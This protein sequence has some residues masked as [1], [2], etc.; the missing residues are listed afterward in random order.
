MPVQQKYNLVFK[1]QKAMLQKTVTAFQYSVMY[2][3]EK[4][5]P[6]KN[7]PLVIAWRRPPEKTCRFTRR[8]GSA[9]VYPEKFYPEFYP[10]YS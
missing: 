2:Q 4:R 3:K 10:T 6:E 7:G 9:G 1:A 5:E 8:R